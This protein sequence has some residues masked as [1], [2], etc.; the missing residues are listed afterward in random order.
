MKT[1]S[2]RPEAFIS[3]N[4][5]RQKIYGNTVYLTNNQEFEFEFFNPTKDN[6]MVR[7]SINGKPISNNGLVL[8]PGVRGWVER[9]IDENRK[10]L[11]ETYTVGGNSETVKKAI[12]DNGNIKIEF[13][14]EKAK[15]VPVNWAI[16]NMLNMNKLPKYRSSTDY[17]SS[18]IDYSANSKLSD[19]V[20]PNSLHRC[21]ASSEYEEENSLSFNSEEM[22]RGFVGNLDAGLNRK[23]K[24]SKSIETGRVEKGS[25]SDQYF[26]RI[27]M[28]FEY[29]PFH[30]I[31]YKLMPISTKPVEFNDLKLKCKKCSAKIKSNWKICPICGNPI[32]NESKCPRCKTDVEPAWNMCPICGEPLK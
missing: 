29:F 4:K 12:E 10:F 6:L 30:T 15:I 31:E 2:V 13:F 5:N 19:K 22:T 16:T 27:D 21:S 26:K 32:N 24:M 17:C 23:M 20:I 1:N 7:I 14:K 18:N 28:E 3:I 11:F 9:Y 25:E 8:R